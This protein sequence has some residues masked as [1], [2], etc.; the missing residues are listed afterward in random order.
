MAVSRFHTSVHSK[1]KIALPRV[2][3]VRTLRNIDDGDFLREYLL[4]IFA[5]KAPLWMFG[6]VVNALRCILSY[7]LHKIPEIKTLLT[8]ETINGRIL[9]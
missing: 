1:M 8:S 6:R 7:A 2:Y 4:T 9:P 3:L 5:K